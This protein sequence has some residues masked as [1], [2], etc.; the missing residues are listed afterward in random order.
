MLCV[1]IYITWKR[2]FYVFSTKQEF[3]VLLCLCVWVCVRAHVYRV[4]VC[5]LLLAVI[6]LQALG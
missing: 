2:L 6:L 5:V 4:S 3:P 1:I